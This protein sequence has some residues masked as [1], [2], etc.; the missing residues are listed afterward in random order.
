MTLQWNPIAS[1][2]RKF[3][4]VLSS[5]VKLTAKRSHELFLDPSIRFAI[6]PDEYS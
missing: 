2:L 4:G 3:V 1:E 5:Q 6:Q